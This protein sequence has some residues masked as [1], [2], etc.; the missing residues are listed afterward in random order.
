MVVSSDG[1]DATASPAVA[2]E[3][4]K[5]DKWYNIVGVFDGSEVKVY[6][7]GEEADSVK[8]A[9][10]IVA[11]VGLISIGDNNEG[12]APDYR[13]VGIIDEVAVYNRALSQGEI[14]QK[15]MSG[16]TLAVRF[17]GKLT[18]TWGGVKAKLG[19]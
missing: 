19:Q 8:H 2:K 7:D 16:H 10:K 11:G 15:M 13:F 12:I 17:E 18:T 3:P 5:L 6:V 1:T 9:G 4:V 14:K